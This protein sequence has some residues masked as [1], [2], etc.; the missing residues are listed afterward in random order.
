MKHLI[1]IAVLV[2]FGSC[3]FSR[4]EDGALPS[5]HSTDRYAQTFQRNP[6][7]RAPVRQPGSHRLL[8]EDEWSLAGIFLRGTQASVLIKNYQTGELRRLSTDASTDGWRLLGTDA[9]REQKH[10]SARI[11]DGSRSGTVT[12]APATTPKPAPKTPSVTNTQGRRLL[13]GNP[14]PPH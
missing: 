12:F 7:T 4:A 10:S 5:G 13:L 14:S 6:F 11:T 3:G 1:I 9:A 2:A 8:I